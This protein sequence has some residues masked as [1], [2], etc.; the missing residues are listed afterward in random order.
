MK[1]HRYLA[2][3]IKVSHVVA[4]VACYTTAGVMRSG[5]NTVV[6][7][8]RA[9]RDL[10]SGV[11]LCAVTLLGGCA[12][13]TTGREELRLAAARDASVDGPRDAGVEE[14]EAT[15]DARPDRISRLI[16]DARALLG[17]IS[18]PGEEPDTVEGGPAKPVCGNNM[19]EG[20]EACDDGNLFDGDNCSSFCTD[21][22]ACDECVAKKPNC[23]QYK[24]PCDGL[25]GVAM[26]GAQPGVAKI[27][28]CR[29]LHK[30]L[31][32]TGCAFFDENAAATCYC[33]TATDACFTTRDAAN[34]PCKGVIEA[35]AETNVPSEIEGMFTAGPLRPNALVQCQADNG[36]AA[37]DPRRDG[38]M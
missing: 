13:G 28:L 2:F 9:R 21:T 29:E 37:C 35:A 17:D 15:V 5:S 19:K 20:S 12:G 38:G 33:G 1:A 10:R 16:F 4:G 32:K 14:R 8:L 23:R 31:V 18:I 36:C 30:C 6:V 24:A 3:V 26:K 27:E 22:T 34:G 25:M 7:G 11:L